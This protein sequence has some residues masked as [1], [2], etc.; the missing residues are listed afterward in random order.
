MLEVTLHVQWLN[1]LEVWRV[2]ASGGHYWDAKTI[3]E[4]PKAV[5]GMLRSEGENLTQAAKE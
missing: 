1:S 5:R 2:S 3:D 4:I